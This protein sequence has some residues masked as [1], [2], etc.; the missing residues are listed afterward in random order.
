VS[1][2]RPTPVRLLTVLALLLTLLPSSQSLAAP[3][4]QSAGTPR[5]GSTAAGKP[6]PADRSVQRYI[7][8]L[9]GDPVAIHLA[10]QKGAPAAR[11]DLAAPSAVG[12]Q[13]ALRAERA[14]ALRAIDAAV[15]DRVSPVTTYELVFNG[16]AL[17]LTGAQAAR[18]AALPQVAAVTKEEVHELTTDVG[19]QWIGATGIW[20]G[21]ATGVFAAT[22]LGANQVPPVT[23]PASGRGIFS[24]DAATRGLS[25]RVQVAGFTEPIT[26]AHL[27]RATDNSVVAPLSGSNGSYSGSV[28][29]SAGDATLLESGDLY[30]NFHTATNPNG[31]IRGDLAGYKGEGVVVGIIDSGINTTH[32]SFAAVGG[33]GYRHL[34]PLGAG[35]Y[36]G[37]CDPTNLPTR[38][39]GNPSGYNPAVSCNDKLIGAWTF[40]ATAPVPSPADEPSP[41]DD[42]GHGTH[43]AS[44]VAGNVLTASNVSGAPFSAVSGVAPH[45]N[46][47]AYDVCGFISNGSV[48]GSCPGA[49][50]LAAIEQA[51]RDQVDVINYSISGGDDPWGD[52]VELAFLAARAAGVIVASSAGNNGPDA[53]TVNHVSPWLL[54]VAATTH[55]RKLLNRVSDFAA[56][57]GPT[58]PPTITGAGF[59]AELALNTTIVYAGSPA[60]GNALC[61][62]FT[63]VQAALVTGKIVICDRGTFGR[64]E[65]AENVQNAGGAGYVLANDA[66]NGNSLN[67]DV[68]P[69]PG[70]H[71]SFDDGVALKSWVDGATNPTARISGTIQDLS[72]SNG[73]VMGSF[74]SR[75]PTLGV[76]AFTLKPDIAAPGVDVFAAYV[77]DGA[78]D[79]DFGFLSGTSMASPHVAGAAAL[80]AGL[81]PDW[82]PGQVQA[83]LMTT[84]LGTLLKEDGTTP[85]TP[86]DSGAGRVRVDRAALA[87]LVLDDTLANFTAADPVI[88]GDPRT[89]NTPSMADPECISTCT[90]TRTVRSTLD[91]PATWTATADDAGLTVTPSSFT[92]APGATQTLTISLNSA[93]KAVNSVFFGR[94]TLSAASGAA[95]DAAFPVAALLK[96]SDLNDTLQVGGAASIE[97]T[98]PVRSVEFDGL[99]LQYNGMTKGTATTLSFQQDQSVTTEVTVPAGAARL[100]AE[101]TQTTSQDADLAVYRD[102]GNGT[103]SFATDT[104][105]CESA[106][107]E[108]LEYCN[109]TEPEAGLYFIEALNFTASAEGAT[110]PVTLVTA[111]VPTASANNFTVS[112]PASS[113]GGA[114]TLTFAFTL[115]GS[116]P[117]DRWYGRFSLTDTGSSQLISASNVDYLHAA[118]ETMSRN[119]GNA[120]RAQV[121]T[122]F[123]NPLTVRV[124]SAEGFPIAGAPVTFAGPSTGASATFSATT[125]NTNL[126]GTASVTATANSAVGTYNVTA[127]VAGGPATASFSLTNTFLPTD[128]FY[129][130]LPLVRR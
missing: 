95:P 42:D 23:S 32:P 88:G 109:L 7:V 33:D 91:A 80:V 87:G 13:A 122:A 29:L 2:S 119:A 4:A 94:V 58:P 30:V 106:S 19:P 65:K 70:V 100:V 40:P 57:A 15:G 47:I 36:K 98:L 64:V 117:G 110:D 28:T 89:L 61:D 31:E 79:P 67:G 54:S 112:G 21:S 66:G 17:D 104:L 38:A 12:Q 39:N 9:H 81:N 62:A 35:K 108:A 34:N 14:A 3:D 56:T 113:P 46:I 48:S 60:I 78:G 105:V 97:A 130:H 20:D 8:R 93:G 121:G 26:G 120:Q 107:A 6:D 116:Q 114:T 37:A 41:N 125:V 63:P 51:T 53:S 115:A 84:A 96:G 44:T 16:M 72:A 99:S 103:F 1:I 126:D 118:A 71:I 127:S 49:A 85:T 24:F 69:I 124:T 101:I 11:L 82:T 27:H 73:D 43:V 52:D 75:G 92:I 5:L 45:A 55:N 68:F 102:N 22:L 50:L 83:A 77:N 128:R 59:S 86:F 111:A 18:V 90:W 25:Y 76:A 123:P 129:L 10:Q 74:S